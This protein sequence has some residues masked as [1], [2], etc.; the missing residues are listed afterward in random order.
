MRLHDES[1]LSV[2]LLFDNRVDPANTDFPWQD[3]W[4]EEIKL[5]L[6]M[7]ALFIRSQGSWSNQEPMGLF[8]NN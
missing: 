1:S 8:E 7:A 6:F 2:P 4:C 5:A 3:A